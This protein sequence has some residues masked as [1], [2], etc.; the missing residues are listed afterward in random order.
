M[1]PE[2]WQLFEL[3]NN[4]NSYSEK[5]ITLNIEIKAPTSPNLCERYDREKFL[6]MVNDEI[7]FYG[8]A[9]I[10][11]ASGFNFEL[12]RGFE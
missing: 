9:G 12:L 6:R 11:I 7:Q 3:I 2:L 5:P 4:Y 8:A 10:S 1:V